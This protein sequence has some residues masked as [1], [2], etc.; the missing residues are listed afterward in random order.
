MDSRAQQ[1]FDRYTQADGAGLAGALA[2]LDAALGCPA[3]PLTPDVVARVHAARAVGAF[4]GTDGARREPEQVRRALAGARRADPAFDFF[5]VV[6]DN[7]N[8]LS[9]AWAA[10]PPPPPALTELPGEG[11]WVDGRPAAVAPTSGV[12]TW[13]QQLPGAG[14][15]FHAWAPDGTS[16][17]TLPAAAPPPPARRRT[18][19]WAVA[20][21]SQEAVG[22]GALATAF[23]IHAGVRRGTVDPDRRA[24][25]QPVNA[26]SAVA[27]P[28]L[29]GTGLLTG[30]IWLALERR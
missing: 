22:V 17:V 21:L 27:G 8:D 5:A 26:A 24:V 9:L 23:A 12:A 11:W 14:P 16:S 2:A 20:A 10:P 15:G 7:G 25:W 3:G 1:V 13:L 6:P 19:P 30:A 28:V 29:C 4:V 18:W